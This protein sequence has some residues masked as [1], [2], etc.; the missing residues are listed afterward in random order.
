MKSLQLAV[1]HTAETIHPMHAFVCES[2][3]IDRELLL[4]GRTTGDSRTLLFFVAGDADA[5]QARL[6]DQPAVTD[7]DVHPQDD[8]FFLYVRVSNDDVDGALLAA[9]ERETVVVVPP[10]EF[11]SD[12]TMHLRLVGPGAD[13]QGILDDLPAE[14]GVDVLEIGSTVDVTATTLT[15]RQRAALRAGWENGYFTVPREGD[16]EAVADELDC[17]VSTA[18]DLLRRAQSRLVADA[19]GEQC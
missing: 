8:G 3:A 5:Y 17:A 15:D 9:F 12:R 14:L 16:I 7:Y 13:L 6:A 2:P 1:E 4:E 19:L 11:R 18:S 10:V